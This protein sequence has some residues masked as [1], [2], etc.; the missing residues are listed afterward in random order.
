MKS[1]HLFALCG[2]LAALFGARPVSVSAQEILRLDWHDQARNRDVPVKIYLPTQTGP[3]PLIVVSHGLGGSREGLEYLG[4][5]WAKAGFLC[6]H[7]QHLGSDE[8]V[9]KGVPPAQTMQAMKRPMNAVNRAKDVS[10]VLDE[11]L[12]QNQTPN[13]PLFGKIDAKKIGV[14]GH[15][16]G[17]WT[18]LASSGRGG[19]LGDSRI[20]ACVALS[21][22]SQGLTREKTAFANY[23]TPTFIFTGTGDDSP[24]GE[25]KAER[26]RDSYDAIAAA[27]KYLI[28]FD[29]ADHMTFESQGRMSKDP[30]YEL[31]H[32][33]ILQS[34]TL[35]WRAY[36]QNDA[37]AKR[38]LGNFGEVLGKSGTF[39]KK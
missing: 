38:E 7:P 15:S 9:W 2:M 24:I 4:E 20:K 37:G 27:A 13:A 12:K 1:N 14:A 39:E 17:A 25:T 32:E 21:A 16:F 23:T 35:F 30:A 26:R 29:G 28:I 22:P 10:F 19:S 36:L 34:T 6:L 31:H 8:S 33:Q 3:R 5:A 11:A 18:A